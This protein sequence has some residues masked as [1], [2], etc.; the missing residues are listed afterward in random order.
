[1]YTLICN[2]ELD[3][4]ECKNSYVQAIEE[5][6]QENDKVVHIDCDLMGCINMTGLWKKYPDRV[7]NAGIAEANAICVACGMSATGLTVFVHT[8]GVFAGR[9]ISD[10]VFLSSGYSNLPIHI[11]GTDPGVTAAV[12]GATHIPFEDCA[13]YMAIPNAI[14]LD[15]CDY[16]QTYALTKKCAQTN[17]LTYMRLIRRAFKTV[18][19]D[20]S[21]FEIGKG[22]TLK[23]G[24]DVTIITS[25]MMVNNSLK[26]HELLKEKGIS[27]RVIDMFTWKPIDEELIIK[28]AKET[29]AIV[30]AENHQVTSG[31]GN[32]VGSVVLR[33][34]PVPQEYIGI[35]NKYGQVGSQDDLEAEYHLTSEDIVEDCIK[36]INRK[37]ES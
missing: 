5:L 29:G 10:Q 11:V 4:R 16:A 3:P 19:S 33:N 28:A 9:R 32:A 31:L 8:F 2:H 21:D 7:I 27:A 35:Q 26:A 25:G 6:L 17:S 1:M 12:N 14:V 15:P 24:N 36:A 34:H 20:D 37:R 22:I 18:Y 30:T 23:E 13:F